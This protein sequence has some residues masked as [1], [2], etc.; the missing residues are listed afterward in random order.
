[1]DGEK[2]MEMKKSNKSL[3]WSLKPDCGVKVVNN[4]FR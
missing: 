3:R 4:L 2:D 1:M